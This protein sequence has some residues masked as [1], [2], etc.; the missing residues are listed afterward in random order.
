MLSLLAWIG[1]PADGVGCSMNRASLNIAVGRRLDKLQGNAQA[2]AGLDG[3]RDGC[4]RH[5]HVPAPSTRVADSPDGAVITGRGAGRFN[6]N[7]RGEE[8]PCR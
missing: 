4:I 8:S 6:R 2:L 3:R 5:S 7:E 1:R